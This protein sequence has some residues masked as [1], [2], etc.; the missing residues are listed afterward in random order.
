MKRTADAPPPAPFDPI[1]GWH[2]WGMDNSYSH[3]GPILTAERFGEAEHEYAVM[4]W[5]PDPEHPGNQPKATDEFCRWLSSHWCH[6]LLEVTTP[7][8]IWIVYT[9]ENEEQNESDLTADQARV[10]EALRERRDKHLLPSHQDAHNLALQL[11]MTEQQVID[12]ETVLD[13]RGLT[14]SATIYLTEDQQRVL[15]L[16]PNSYDVDPSDPSTFGPTNGEIVEQL[17]MTVEEVKRHMRALAKLGWISDPPDARAQRSRQV[18]FPLSR[19]AGIRYPTD[20]QYAAAHEF[21]RNADQPMT[22]EFEYRE[23]KS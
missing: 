3:G 23:D 6:G 22:I 9:D 7:G 19:F 5:H 11:G 10:L 21:I 16:L 17:G 12:A 20:E 8:S 1:A 18:T 4:V 15:N 14:V 13:G 2:D